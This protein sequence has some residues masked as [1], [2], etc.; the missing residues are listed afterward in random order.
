MY[1]RSKKL[2]MKTILSEEEKDRP[3]LVLPDPECQ[4]HVNN[5]RKS[6]VLST[7]TAG[8]QMIVDIICV[9]GYHVPQSFTKVQQETLNLEAQQKMIEGDQRSDRKRVRRR[10]LFG[11]TGFLAAL[12]LFLILVSL[13]LVFTK[14]R[15]FSIDSAFVD[16]VA[17]S[18]TANATIGFDFR[19]NF[20]KVSVTEAVCELES[21][22]IFINIEALS[23]DT[24]IQKYHLNA[25]VDAEDL[26]SHGDLAWKVATGQDADPTFLGCSINLKIWIGYFIPIEYTYTISDRNNVD[27]NSTEV[28]KGL[29]PDDIGEPKLQADIGEPKFQAEISGEVLL[30]SYR[31]SFAIPESVP[32]QVLLPGFVLAA[33]TA[34]S[35][36]MLM[37]FEGANIQDL[38]KMGALTLLVACDG[39]CAWYNPLVDLVLEGGGTVEVTVDA[40][41]SFIEYVLGRHHDIKISKKRK[42]FE[43]GRRLEEICSL[44]CLDLTA[45]GANAD[46]CLGFQISEGMVIEGQFEA[47]GTTGSASGDLKWTELEDEDGI[48]IHLKSLV[49]FNK[50]TK[51]DLGGNLTAEIGSD[52]IQISSTIVNSAGN[53]PIVS[54]LHSLVALN[55]D[56][57]SAKI[58][59]LFLMWKE[60]DVVNAAGAFSIDF[61][62]GSLD[63]VF[64]NTSP[65]WPL[66][67]AIRGS[68]LWEDGVVVEDE[69]FVVTLDQA[70]LSFRNDVLVETVGRLSLDFD[71]SSF[72]LVASD[73]SYEC[74]LS[75]SLLNSELTFSASLDIEGGITIVS[76]TNGFLRDLEEPEGFQLETSSTL[77]IDGNLELK[78][79][80]A[81]SF[82]YE[83]LDTRIKVA[84]TAGR[85]PMEFNLLGRTLEGDNYFQVSLDELSLHFQNKA[86]MD[87]VVLLNVDLSGNFGLAFTV[88]DPSFVIESNVKL[89]I[90]DDFSQPE[91]SDTVEGNFLIQIDNEL[92]LDFGFLGAIMW[93]SMDDGFR[94]SG[95]ADEEAMLGASFRIVLDVLNE[96][97]SL[98]GI[99][100]IE[101][102]LERF[103]FIVDKDTYADATGTMKLGFDNQK[104]QISI[105]NTARRNFRAA[106]SLTWETNTLPDSLLVSITQATIEVSGRS[107]VDVTGRIFLQDTNER[108]YGELEWRTVGD[109]TRVQTEAV[110]VYQVFRTFGLQASLTDG[111]LMF[112]NKQLIDWEMSVEIRDSEETLSGEFS[113]VTENQEALVQVNTLLGFEVDDS[114]TAR[115]APFCLVIDSSV[116]ANL[117]TD[118]FVTPNVNSASVVMGFHA[119]DDN[120]GVGISM[121]RMEIDWPGDTVS[122]SMDG[123]FLALPGRSSPVLEGGMEFE[124]DFDREVMEFHIEN[125]STLQYIDSSFVLDFGAV[126]G[127]ETDIHDVSCFVPETAIASAKSPSGNSPTVAAVESPFG[128]SPTVAAPSARDSV[129][130]DVSIAVL[131]FGSGWVSLVGLLVL[132]IYL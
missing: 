127:G 123:A 69:V 11:I 47:F 107:F 35:R 44:T 19:P 27:S 124:V 118:L 83:N 7:G 60:V 70:R 30:L 45:D 68:Y 24:S 110:I 105:R 82:L 131:A 9:G 81:F 53:W 96:Y 111:K 87:A 21:G 49:S 34:T 41:Q 65:D 37:H 130:T 80:V 8:D 25:D 94:V 77:S 102:N 61:V 78:L 6:L 13:D 36:T 119:D 40:D 97:D 10:L 129:N 114:V 54:R 98:L 66:Q 91:Y 73:P 16:L 59:E 50:D 88:T 33:G 63:G 17:T 31:P 79:S 117:T 43:S 121:D 57:F 71:K 29:K 95:S 93:N 3:R 85:W 56:I 116:L 23:T 101:T 48:T 12:V 39:E 26:Q 38:S 120:N 20:S 4:N 14:P 89:E 32:V 58:D 84:N 103:L 108:N 18:P 55:G 5:R 125:N 128:N 112:D 106:S 64:S 51:M 75:G 99:D 1:A 115:I 22:V 67:S 92:V 2:P 113:V 62:D 86:I 109:P 100:R 90:A 28:G 74:H 132:G 126:T 15:D 46:V 42:S 122:M 72:L 76:L 52:D 104:V